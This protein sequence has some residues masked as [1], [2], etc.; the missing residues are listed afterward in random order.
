MAI[1]IA[2]IIILIWLSD[3]REL[4]DQ[5]TSLEG[6]Y[7]LVVLILYV[8]N[9]LTKAFRW[10]LLVNTSE[11]KVLFKDTFKFYV[12]ALG[13]NNITPGK[14][15]GEPVR[16]YLLKRESEVPVGHG[17]AS[18][19]I[20]KVL[21]LIIITVIAIFG[22]LLILP[23]LSEAQAMVYMG[24]VLATVV[25]ILL[26]VGIMSSQR[27]L[28]GTVDRSARLIRKV[29]R[30]SLDEKITG[31]VLGFTKTFEKGIKDLSKRKEVLTTT[32]FLS[33]MI[34][35]NEALRLMLIMLALPTPLAVGF[36]AVLIASSV[37]NIFGLVLPLGA[38]NMLGIGTV[39][40]ALGLGGSAI[41]AASLTMVA[42]SLWL[43]VPLCVLA[44][45]VTGMKV[46]RISR[47]VG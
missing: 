30:G 21:D 4:W 37:A 13:L 5:I 18:I 33:T 26:I 3:P 14:I 43:S 16:A 35:M 10:H 31:A 15:G 8:I 20:E 27:L 39:F 28:R 42:T 23:L 36:G 32:L 25:I 9:L 24:V 40:M 11:V 41:G 6:R 47:K 22:A 29:S 2:I 34:W 45:L 46:P 12:I 38:G 19:I 7:I 1:S 17:M 44:I